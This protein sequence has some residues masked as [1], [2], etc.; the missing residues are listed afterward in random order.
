MASMWDAFFAVEAC[1]YFK[2]GT[3]NL[4]AGTSSSGR[5]GIQSWA[6]TPCVD[7]YIRPRSP[8]EP[9]KIMPIWIAGHSC[10]CKIAYVAQSAPNNSTAIRTSLRKGHSATALSSNAAK[11]CCPRFMHVTQYANFLSKCNDSVTDPRF[12]AVWSWVCK[13]SFCC[14][15]SAG[16]GHTWELEEAVCEHAV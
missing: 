2:H 16:N 15:S 13:C 8:P 12:S 4:P 10:A 7:A 6:S 5:P 3:P 9:K 1:Q 11:A 14:F